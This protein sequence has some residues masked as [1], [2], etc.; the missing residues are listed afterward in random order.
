MKLKFVGV[1][2]LWASV[3]GASPVISAD[4]QGTLISLGDIPEDVIDVVYKVI[5]WPYKRLLSAISTKFYKLLKGYENKFDF[6]PT[7]HL[8]FFT[9][10]SKDSL[11]V[12]KAGASLVYRFDYD[13]KKCKQEALSAPVQPGDNFAPHNDGFYWLKA[14]TGDLIQATTKETGLH[15]QTLITL[16]PGSKKL[17]SQADHL[18]VL[19]TLKDHDQTQAFSLPNPL[20]EVKV[21]LLQVPKAFRNIYAMSNK[22]IWITSN[23][24][25]V[26]YFPCE[27]HN[28]MERFRFGNV[29]EVLID[30]VVHDDIIITYCID[31]EVSST[32]QI[33]Y[34][35]TRREPATPLPINMAYLCCQNFTIK[36]GRLLVVVGKP[37]R[38]TGLDKEKK[39]AV[40]VYDLVKNETVL[41]KLLP[42]EPFKAVLWK[43]Q[44]ILLCHDK[45][46]VTLS[47]INTKNW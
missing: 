12:L 42:Q 36:E 1:L 15:E 40:V 35:T 32:W 46:Q 43:D 31:N 20:S 45:K 30:L 25:E 22:D 5:D 47:A 33:F 18:V 21:C 37:F 16:G 29:D 44:L 17:L 23:I 38:L 4:H 19:H 13:F 7:E 24:N 41:V 27:N 34:K 26:I 11:W 28:G 8:V 3:F 6:P 10:L 39:S 2:F 9:C 14:S